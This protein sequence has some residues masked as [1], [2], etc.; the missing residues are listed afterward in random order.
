MR[1]TGLQV[2]GDDAVRDGYFGVKAD[3]D[4]GMSWTTR[5][6]RRL[7]SYQLKVKWLW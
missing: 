3:R 4:I 7:G 5:T 6:F 2:S 1:Q